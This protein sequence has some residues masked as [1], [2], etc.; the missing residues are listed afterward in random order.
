MAYS[1]FFG[2]ENVEQME[3]EIEFKFLWEEKPVLSLSLS[4]CPQKISK[5]IFS[6]RVDPRP[7]KLIQFAS[8]I[9]ISPTRTSS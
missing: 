6:S 2:E 7:R 3:R 1:L 8:K 5:I 9:Q 4:L